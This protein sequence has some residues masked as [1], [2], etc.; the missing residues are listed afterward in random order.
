MIFGIPSD[1]AEPSQNDSSIFDTTTKSFVDDVIKASAEVAVIVDFWSPRCGPC[2]QLTPILEKLTK[3]ANGS[4]KLAKMNVDE[5]PA[6]FSQI[7]MQLGMQSVPAVIVFKNGQPVDGFMGALPECQ[8]QE[9]ISRHAGEALEAGLETVLETA[10]EAFDNDDIE[11]AQS[12]FAAILDED[13]EHIGARVG[14]AKCYIKQNKLDLARQTLE[15]IEKHKDTNSD[16]SGVYAMLELADMGGADADV[17]QLERQVADNPEDY[18]AYFDLALA[19]NAKGNKKAA[20]EALFAI[21]AHSKSWNNDAAKTQLIKFFEAWG[22]KDPDT[23]AGRKQLS[24][25][26][27]S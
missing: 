5:H 16:V 23:I 22:S 15:P 19:Q 4:I 2:K 26:L 13:A 21:M 24:L 25:L 1:K 7:A 11:T 14:L 10:Q 9:F 20:T 12:V 18:Q 17:S 8:V 27:F 3:Q 6:I